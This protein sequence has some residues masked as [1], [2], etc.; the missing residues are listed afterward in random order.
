[1]TD[2]LSIILI[3]SLMAAFCVLVLK[4][5]AAVALLLLQQ[6]FYFCEDLL[7]KKIFL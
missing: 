7:A 2:F 6:I 1:M 5:A 4:A 3:Q